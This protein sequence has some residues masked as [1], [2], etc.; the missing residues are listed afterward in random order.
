MIDGSSLIFRLAQRIKTFLHD[1]GLLFYTCFQENT[2]N[3]RCPVCILIYENNHE[4]KDEESKW[5]LRKKRCKRCAIGSIADKR[6]LN[7]RRVGRLSTRSPPSCSALSQLLR[8]PGNACCVPDSASLLSRANNAADASST[9]QRPG[10]KNSVSA[11]RNTGIP[12]AWNT[13]YQK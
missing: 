4:M 6:K 3:I 7:R 2:Q 8:L 11:L 1:I 5:S 10:K 12:F 13:S 9:T